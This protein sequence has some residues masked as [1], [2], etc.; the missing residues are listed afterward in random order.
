MP[1]EPGLAASFTHTV[2]DSDTAIAVGSGDVPVLGTPTVLALAERAT[3]LAVVDHITAD[4]TTVGTR[5][6]LEHLVPTAVGETVRV[7]VV[8]E[9]VDGRRLTFGV[10]VSD[11]ER[12]VAHGTI[13]RVLVTRERFLRT[14]DR[15]R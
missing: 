6:E 3:C 9:A 2:I 1:L 7:D 10:R 11:A 12:A 4:L 15:D 8:L 5:V 14:L 13:S